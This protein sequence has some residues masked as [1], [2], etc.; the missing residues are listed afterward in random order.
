[1][2][3]VILLDTVVGGAGSTLMMVSGSPFLT[4]NSTKEERA[5]LFSVSMAMFT[6]SGI[7]G[8]FLGGSL[9]VLWGRIMSQPV[10]SAVVYRSTLLSAYMLLLLAV[11]PYFLLKDTPRPKGQSMGKLMEL[12]SPRLVVKLLIPEL[13]TAF[14]AGL[15]SPFS[16]SFSLNTYRPPQFKWGLYSQP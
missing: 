6:V 16:T 13:L 3:N 7:G 8:S 10:D 15:L 4:E 12:K 2:P 5:H 1:M 9:P 11:I 14:G